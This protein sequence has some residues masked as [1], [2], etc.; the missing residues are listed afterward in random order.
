[1]RTPALHDGDAKALY[2]M[3]GAH[4]ARGSVLTGR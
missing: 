4:S 2:E 3:V 1:M